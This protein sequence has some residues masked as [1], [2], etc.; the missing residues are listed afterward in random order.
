V[1]NAGAVLAGA[2]N[3]F[4]K[5]VEVDV[6]EFAGEDIAAAVADLRAAFTPPRPYAWLL[7]AIEPAEPAPPNR[8]WDIPIAEKPPAPPPPRPR[9]PRPGGPR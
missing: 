4:V 5:G 8:W 3:T 9:R 2:G 7:D 1:S 6:R